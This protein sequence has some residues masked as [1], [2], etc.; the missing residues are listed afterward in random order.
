MYAS[1]LKKKDVDNLASPAFL[2]TQT[3]VGACLQKNM[4]VAM[5][6]RSRVI[7]HLDKLDKT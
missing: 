2:I 1:L 7:Y 5:N 3:A 6:V 4:Y